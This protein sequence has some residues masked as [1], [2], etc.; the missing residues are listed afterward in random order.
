MSQPT[1]TG[2]SE[3]AGKGLEALIPRVKEAGA[4][5]LIYGLGSALQAGL[6]F[7]LLPIYVQSFDPSTYGVFALLTM[8]GALGGVVLSLGAPSAV[9]RSYPDYADEGDRRRVVGTSLNLVLI[10]AGVVVLLGGPLAPLASTAL[11]GTDAFTLHLWAVVGTALFGQLNNIYLVLLRFRRQ[12]LMVVKINVGVV[13]GS[14][15]LIWLLVVQLKMGLWGPILGLLG[16]QVV[17]FVVLAVLCRRDTS[18]LGLKREWPIQLR[19]GIPSAIVGLQYYLLDSVDRVFLSKMLDVDAVGVYSVGYRIGMAVQIVLVQP[20]AQ[21]WTPMRLEYRSDANAP[22]LFSLILTYYTLAG[23]TVTVSIALFAPEILALIGSGT[24]YFQ[25]WSVVG[26]V[27]LGHLA[28]G[29]IGVVD[30]GIIFNRRIDFHFWG[31]GLAMLL[32]GLLNLLLIPPFGIVGAAIA[33]LVS[34]ATLL[35]IAGAFSQRLYA[36]PWEYSR[37]MTAWAFALLALVLGATLG[38]H[39]LGL[40]LVILVYTILA[41]CTFVLGREE[42]TLL[43]AL[44]RR[45]TSRAS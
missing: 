15:V 7:L 17:Q 18:W 21:I 5:T 16:S 39:N 37:V 20:F 9:A 27:M 1:A 43:L 13:L 24:A 31:F 32:N 12:S 2:I 35:V 42:K 10:G 3:G 40:R 26:L 8:T 29:A 30:C 45:A 44:L 28:Y 41:W 6:G 19:Y 38:S 11:F 34:Y 36:V 4:H 22:R 23:L 14:L 25:A 33:T